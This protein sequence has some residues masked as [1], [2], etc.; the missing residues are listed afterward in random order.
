MDKFKFT[1][2][3]NEIVNMIME[4]LL[5]NAKSD[6]AYKVNCLSAL[7]DSYTENSDVASDMVLKYAKLLKEYKS[8][9]VG[10]G[11]ISKFEKKHEILVLLAER[12][13]KAQW[14]VK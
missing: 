10:Y 2:I 11:N 6:I 13:H 9:L 4:E 8:Y 7:I 1:I 14:G 5:L 12:N 3:K